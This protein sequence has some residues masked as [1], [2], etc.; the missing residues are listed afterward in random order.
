MNNSS[1][2]CKNRNDTKNKKPSAWGGGEKERKKERKKSAI[3]EQGQHTSHNML[4][5]II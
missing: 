1:I 5:K 3:S 2:K 4:R